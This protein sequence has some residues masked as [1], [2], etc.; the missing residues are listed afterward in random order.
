[1]ITIEMQFMADVKM[2]CEAC[3]GLRFKPEILE[4]KFHGKNNQ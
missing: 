1:M 2:V 3:N 4:V